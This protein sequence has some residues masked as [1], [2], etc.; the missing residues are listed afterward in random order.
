M[1]WKAV[2]G[3]YKSLIGYYSGDVS[4]YAIQCN[5]KFYVPTTINGESITYTQ[6]INGAFFILLFLLNLEARNQWT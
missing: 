3:R 4:Y 1:K 5:I 6:P 2:K